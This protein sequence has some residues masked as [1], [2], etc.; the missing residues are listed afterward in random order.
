MEQTQRRLTCTGSHANRSKVTL[1]CVQSNCVQPPFICG[2]EEC[3]CHALH[4][5]HRIIF[6]RGVLEKANQIP[7]VDPD[8]VAA[9]KS[10]SVMIDSTIKELQNLKSV[11][12]D[13]ADSYFASSYR[14]QEARTRLLAQDST[15]PFTGDMLCNILDEV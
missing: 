13:Q 11:H 7:S 14:W 2:E 4:S 15:Y 3:E 6:L 10:M 12:E 5:S 9:R 1:V 8:F